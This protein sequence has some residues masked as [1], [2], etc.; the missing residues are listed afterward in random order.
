MLKTLR[1]N[2]NSANVMATVAVVIA[3]GGTSY[4]AL[5]LPRNSV[6]ERQ[7][8]AGAVR[9]SEVRNG[10]LG[11]KDL[12]SDA[13]TSLRGAT[14]PTGP[15]GPAGPAGTQL[16]AVVSAAGERI[17]GTATS[18]GSSGGTGSYLIGFARSVQGCAAT[19][20]LGTAD[21]STAVPG[22]ITVNI[23]NGQA[24]VQTYG[25]DGSPASAPFHLLVA[26]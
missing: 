26:C 2:V 1:N 12:S 18:G 5:T 15:Q 6:G 9:T 24:G 25:A 3:L 7:I 13:R 8:R 22:R 10:T 11:I 4:A 16:Y 19:A 14:G 20:T 23:V 21:G 17:A